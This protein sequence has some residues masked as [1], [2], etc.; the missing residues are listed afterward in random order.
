MTFRTE[1]RRREGGVLAALLLA[2]AC[3]GSSNP[4]A[5]G[6]PGT[7]GGDTITGR[8]RIGWAQPAQDAAQLATFDFAIYV[9]G[10]RTLLSNDTCAP[11]SG[12]NFDCSAPLP[13]LTAG[14]HTLELAAFIVSN[15][16]TLESDRSVSLR[17]TVAATTAPG[18]AALPIDAT[19]TSSEG[20]QFRASIVARGL[21]DPTDLAVAPDGRI[22]VT[23]RAGRVQIVAPDGSGDSVA[24]ELHGVAPGDETGLT[25]VALHPQFERTGHVF[26]GYGADGDRRDAGGLRIARFR[27]RNGVLAEG[28]ML[29]RERTAAPPHV[30]VRFGRD[31]KLYAA[32]S[33][34]ADPRDAQSAASPLGKILRFNEDGSTP[35][36]NPAATA[37]FSSGHRDPRALAWHPS[38]GALWEVERDREAGD[39]LNAVVAG[40]D[41]GWPLVRGATPSARS[42]PAALV[43]PPGTEVS[44]AAFIPARSRSPM[45]GELIV[46]SR[47][48]ED[49]LRVRVGAGREPSGLV[50]GILQGRYGRIAAIA[51]AG[52][53]TIYA[54]TGNH[55]TWG[56]GRDVLVRIAAAIQE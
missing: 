1:A 51:V 12:G 15:G 5:P 7:G 41:Y 54:A 24:L 55:E 16:V 21:D 32:V 10:T 3:G 37:T 36:D 50:E 46:A 6:P 30:V 33:A 14:Q 2:T 4:P 18:D 27:E 48:A 45:A 40:A 31:G 49:L 38:N 22:F 47:G 13:P 42:V 29:A 9:D 23:E 11:G 8:E 28:A 25:A 20:H 44:G 56:A 43:L 19:V 26:L 52:D 35:R 34:G 17:V 39:E 53:G